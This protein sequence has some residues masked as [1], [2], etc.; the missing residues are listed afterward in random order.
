[1]LKKLTIENYALIDSLELD[2]NSGLTIITGE[3]GAGKSIMLGALSL[4]MGGRAD[5][6]AVSDLGRKAVV[7]AEF[8]V[9]GV[10]LSQWYAEN[11]LEPESDII[12]VRREISSTGRSRAFVNDSVVNLGSLGSLASRLIDIHSQHA[13]AR[14]NDQAARLEIVDAMADN[15]KLREEY[16]EAFRRFMSVRSKLRSLREAQSKA[17][18]NREF[19]MF[20]Y[21]QLDKLKPKRGELSEIERRYEIL[22]D[23]DDIRDKLASIAAKLSDN[24]AGALAQI[25]EAKRVSEAIDFGML[26]KSEPESE[27]RGIVSRIDALTVELRDIYETVVD[28]LD[29]VDADPAELSRISDRMTAYYGAMKQFR[30]KNGDELV[31]LYKELK[32]KLAMVDGGDESIAELE[33]EGRRLA[34]EMKR[35]AD[36]LTASRCEGAQ[37]FAAQV[38]DEA[39]VLG[40]PNLQFEVVVSEAKLSVTGQDRIEFQCSFNKN[41]TP[42][43][44]TGIASGGEISRLMLTIKGIMSRRMNLPTIIFDEVDT[45]VS[46]EIADKMGE[47]MRRMGEGMQVLTITHLPQVAAKGAWHYK[48]F[49]TDQEERTLTSVRRLDTEER[50]REIAAMISGSKVAKE[51]LDNA[52]ALLEV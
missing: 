51:A 18:E 33:A 52:R 23:A 4:L 41:Q 7:E 29:E 49:K 2:F 47:M 42:M 5:T 38:T 31:A 11:D 27:Q 14:L 39:R 13:N 30:V 28:A 24:G 26:V 43:P 32:Q 48:V 12:S 16:A 3:T 15:A 9:S 35:C 46:G 19:L 8:D 17:E 25:Q 44:L 50:V 21:E 10:D 36:I 34:K 37:A 1:M 22:S 45:G 6:R 20:Q 40:L